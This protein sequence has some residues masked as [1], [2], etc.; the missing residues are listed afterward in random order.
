[1]AKGDELARFLLLIYRARGGKRGMNWIRNCV[2]P[3][4]STTHRMDPHRHGVHASPIFKVLPAPR[5]FTDTY[6]HS[7]IPK[8]THRKQRGL[9]GVHFFKDKPIE[10][11]QPR[12]RNQTTTTCHF[13]SPRPDTLFQQ[14]EGERYVVWFQTYLHARHAPAR[15]ISARIK[16][17]TPN[18][19][20]GVT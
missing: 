11:N 8:S 20:C 18:G 19:G 12:R 17:Y 3:F 13:S 2:F 1:V 6:T 10:V 5:F 7:S 4:G 14:G 9:L 16:T 15:F